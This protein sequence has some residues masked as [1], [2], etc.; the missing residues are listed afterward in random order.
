MSPT[1]RSTG[2]NSQR[3]D[4]KH[5]NDYR[6]GW[7][8]KNPFSSFSSSQVR[9]SFEGDRA[10]TRQDQFSGQLHPLEKR[11]GRPKS[12]RARFLARDSVDHA[13]GARQSMCSR[14]PSRP[15]GASVVARHEQA[16]EAAVEALPRR[17]W[18]LLSRR[19]GAARSAQASAGQRV[20]ARKRWLNV[21][22]RGTCRALMPKTMCRR[23]ASSQ[24]CGSHQLPSA[25]RG[26]IAP[27][28]PDASWTP[29]IVNSR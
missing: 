18:Q 26:T 15:L 1:R 25:R 9:R 28:P 27:R 11:R 29:T 21:F 8:V 23:P 6:Q 2:G 13:E 5:I 16:R 12:P 7:R 20:V 4:A 17:L 24:K 19:R 22:L 3:P 10:A 14:R